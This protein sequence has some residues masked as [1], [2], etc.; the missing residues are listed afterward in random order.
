[1]RLRKAIQNKRRA[2]LSK[3]VILL[4]DNARP[5]T[6]ACTK[7]L[8]DKFGWEIFNTPLQSGL[9]TERLPPLS[10]DEDLVSHSALQ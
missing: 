1:M 10:Q 7:A 4:H 2:L 5:H 9:G 8:L 6:A 3:G